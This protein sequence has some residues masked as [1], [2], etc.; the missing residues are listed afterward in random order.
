M[1]QQKPS[2]LSSTN[3]PIITAQFIASR[4]VV[5][6]PAD[7]RRLYSEAFYGKPVG[8]RK[9]KSSDFDRPLELGLLE[10]YYLL[11]KNR[12]QIIDAK[13]KSSISWKTIFFQLNLFHVKNHWTLTAKIL[14]NLLTVTFPCFI[15]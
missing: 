14:N 13:K 10:A 2:K 7:G 8:I 6:N 4:V 3:D 5:W 15:K 1:P 9:P 11:S 12:I